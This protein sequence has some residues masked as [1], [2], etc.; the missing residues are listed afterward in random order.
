MIGPQCVLEVV[1]YHKCSMLV[2]VE[3]K[4]GGCKSELGNHELVHQYS[5]IGH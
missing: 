1:L 4:N 2:S 3:M 5:P